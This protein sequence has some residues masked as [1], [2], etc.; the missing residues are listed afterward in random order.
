[1]RIEAWQDEYG[2]IVRYNMAYINHAIFAGD[3]GRVIGYDNAHG[4]HHKHCFGK[5]FRVENFKNYK[6]LLRQFEN[7]IK[8]IIK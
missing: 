8:E 1:M 4:Y 3:N 6:E 7:E 5:I 2:Q